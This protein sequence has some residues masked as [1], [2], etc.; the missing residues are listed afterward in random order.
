MKLPN[1]REEAVIR[2][3]YGIAKAKSKGLARKHVK[4]A[5]LYQ[6][7]LEIE[8]KAFES[9]GRMDELFMLF[10]RNKRVS[11]PDFNK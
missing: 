10:M 6:Q 11:A 7:M 3:R 5:E 4:N 1:S 2:M 9:T 8:L